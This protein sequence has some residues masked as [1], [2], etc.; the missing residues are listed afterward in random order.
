VQYEI[1]VNGRSRRVTIRRVD[2][3]F[4]VSVDGREW[5]VDSTRVGAHSISL[6]IETPAGGQLL[7]RSYQVSL[8]PDAA[9]GG[10]VVRVGDTPVKVS[11]NGR[12]G[13]GKKEDGSQSGGGPQRIVAPMPG[14]IA[15]VLV[16]RGEPV[17]S[18]QPIIVIE[19]MKMENELRAV[20]DGTLAEIHVQ[21]GQSVEA[22]ALLA[23]IH[24]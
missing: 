4:V 16:K 8:A 14:K 12:R 9:S 7:S 13:W 6:L 22:G 3:C 1:D 17:Q 19:A 21:D 2:S 11:V 24:R 18:R 15:R 10:Q 23:V 20:T 5:T